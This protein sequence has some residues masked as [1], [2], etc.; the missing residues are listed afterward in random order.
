MK[1]YGM[2]PSRSMRVAWAAEEAGVDFEYI[3]MQLGS[4]EQ[5]G[6]ASAEYLAIN[7]QG[8][9]PSIA[10]GDLVVT[11][12]G[13]IVNYLAAKAPEKNLMPADGTP[14][15]AK[16]D[17]M[18]YF[19]LTELEQPLWSNGKHRFAIPEEFRIADMVT[20]TAPF[21]YEKAQKTLLILLGDRPYAAGDNFTMA[22][23]LLAH[24]ISWAEKFEFDVDS[25][26]LDYRNK[27]M[28]REA[29]GKVQAKI[30]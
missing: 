12:S 3:A 6:T 27:M 1:I 18:C 9:V 21:E 24:T 10:D 17:E 16:Y 13:A 7:P 30:M 8:K 22:D 29:F 4:T 28:Q 19:I 11:E 20:K 5:N 15:R 23:V 2:G 26:L 25:K 14:E